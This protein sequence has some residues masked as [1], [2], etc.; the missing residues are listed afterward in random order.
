[1]SGKLIWFPATAP[2][3]PPKEPRLM[4]LRRLR[5]ACGPIH[6]DGFRGFQ[7]G[8]C[9]RAVPDILDQA[10]AVFSTHAVDPQILNGWR[11]HSPPVVGC[12]VGSDSLAAGAGCSGSTQRSPSPR[13]QSV[14][15]D[16]PSSAGSLLSGRHLSWPASVAVSLF[17]PT[18]IAIPLWV[19]ALLPRLVAP[20]KAWPSAQRPSACSGPACWPAPRLRPPFVPASL[21]R[22]LRRLPRRR[23]SFPRPVPR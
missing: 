12:S 23:R 11:H 20:G 4:D 7:P 9:P 19:A 14:P 17:L 16:S 10:Q 1:M 21:P 6:S 22:R 18:Q 15:P 13:Q 5:R 8:R 3:L 2:A